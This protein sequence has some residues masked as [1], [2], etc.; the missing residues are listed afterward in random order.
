MAK[1]RTYE[2]NI[3]ELYAKFQAQPATTELSQTVRGMVSIS[4]LRS[5]LNVVN[6]AIDELAQVETDKVVR[7]IIQ[8]IGELENAAALKPGGT[9]TQ[10]K[11][12][13]TTDWFDKLEKDFKRLLAFY[14]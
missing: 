13:R 1:L 2:Q 4:D 5:A 6:E 8:D 11:I 14:V 10:K 12:V 9:R 7:G 3:S